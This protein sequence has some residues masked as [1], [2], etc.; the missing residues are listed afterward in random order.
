MT[1]T[2]TLT[3]EEEVPRS[4]PIGDITVGGRHGR[5]KEWKRRDGG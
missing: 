3:G 2:N 5:G 4:E 1:F